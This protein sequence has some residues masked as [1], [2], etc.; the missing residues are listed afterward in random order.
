MPAGGDVEEVLTAVSASNADCKLPA[1]ILPRK[2]AI[3]IVCIFMLSSNRLTEK[4][5]AV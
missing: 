3:F 2:G 4:W 5:E 1:V